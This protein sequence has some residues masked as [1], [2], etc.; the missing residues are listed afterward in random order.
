MGSLLGGLVTRTTFVGW[1][2]NLLVEGSLG[3]LLG[4][5]GHVALWIA[6]VARPDGPSPAYPVWLSM[7]L[8]T[9]PFALT[10]RVQILCFFTMYGKLRVASRVFFDPIR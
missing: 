3:A 9:L 10:I 4:A 5:A 7:L 8:W 2:F 6:A 1:K